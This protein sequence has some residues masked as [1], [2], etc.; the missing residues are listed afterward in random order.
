MDESESQL[1]LLL[2]LGS[3]VSMYIKAIRFLARE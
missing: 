3:T 2:R 1:R